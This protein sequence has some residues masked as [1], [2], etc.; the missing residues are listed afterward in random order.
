MSQAGAREAG[1]EDTR[2]SRPRTRQ[3]RHWAW[4]GTGGPG[5][6][7]GMPI[8][9]AKDFKVTLKR[10]IGYLKPHR[11]PIIV[12]ATAVLSTVFSI[13]GPKIMGKATTKIFEGLV[14]KM[15]GAPGAKID[16]GYIWR[17]FSS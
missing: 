13:L 3:V 7:M 4:R 14:A 2:A 12:F 9:K 16:F 11:F 8:Q 6:M 10:L 17:S 15:K 5:R 1:L